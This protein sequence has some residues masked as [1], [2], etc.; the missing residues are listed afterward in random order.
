MIET[1]KLPNGWAHPV[2]GEKEVFPA[3]AVAQ[4]RDFLAKW[5]RIYP[6][7]STWVGNKSQSGIGKPSLFVRF[8]CM[9]DGTTLGICEVEE[10]P[11][12]MG[13]TGYLNPAFKEVLSH[14]R[15]KWPAFSWVKDPDRT[16]DDELWLG[17]GLTLAEALE[18][19]EKDPEAL[20]LVRSRPEKAQ[21]YTLEARAVSSVSME[22]RKAYGEELGLWKRSQLVRGEGLWAEQYLEPS[23][24]GSCVAKP[25]IGTRARDIRAYV[26][27]H[28]R[29]RLVHTKSER[30]VR[31]I[32]RMARNY[33]HIFV[34][35][36]IPPMNFDH[37][38]SV[39]GY[40]THNGIY[41]MYFGYDPEVRTWTPMGGM[42]AASNKSVIVHGTPETVFGPLVCQ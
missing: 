27:P 42:W 32:E 14:L 24:S 31:E 33:T 22:G 18:R 10:R 25:P 12:G 15:S 30:N 41:R 20:F 4:A 39:E 5:E 26:A 34:Q 35:R 40:E 17:P 11:C 7:G 16:T 28:D 1:K 3:A 2:S 29:Q 21:Y 8:D 13:A 9:W 37:L 19:K 38:S 6:A 23:L 36:L